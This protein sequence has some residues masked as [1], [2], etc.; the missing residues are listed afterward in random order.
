MHIMERSLKSKIPLSQEE[1][2]KTELKETGSA[3]AH[4]DPMDS[5]RRSSLL[6]SRIFCDE[7]VSTS[8]ENALGGVL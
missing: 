6:F 8:S 5:D 7:P 2:A 1:T 4:S 3:R